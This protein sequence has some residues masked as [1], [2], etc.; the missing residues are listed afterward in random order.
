[1]SGTVQAENV[2]PPIDL[3]RSGT[4]RTSA[5]I[6]PEH[7]ECLTTLR[8]LLNDLSPDAALGEIASMLDK[9]ADNAELF[10]RIKDWAA[11]MRK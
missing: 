1:M 11:A 9:T 10:S 5:L 3:L 4:K 6:S 7:T 2:F 8:S